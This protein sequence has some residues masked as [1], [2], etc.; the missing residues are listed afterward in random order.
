MTWNA[1]DAKVGKIPPELRRTFDTF[2]DF[3]I[4]DVGVVPFSLPHDAAD[5]VGYRLWGGGLSIAT[6]TDLGH[7]PRS[8]RDAVAGS[9]LV[10][11]E[12]NHDPDML[13][14]NDH[15]NERLKQRILGNR[16]HLSNAACADALLQIVESG[17]KNVILGHLSGEN[18]TPSLAYHISEDRM[19]REGIRLG[20]DLTLDVALRDRVGNIY[21][22]GDGK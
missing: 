16:G 10:L 7:F 2:S 19:T 21:T 1:M 22:L 9:S 15:Y 18:N 14:H 13:R 4:G 17:T 5:P 8:V 6:A 12:S 11:L 20:Q 3:Y